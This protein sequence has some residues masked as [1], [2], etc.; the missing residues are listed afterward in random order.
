MN[1]NLYRKITIVS[2]FGFVS[3]LNVSCKTISIESKQHFETSKNITLGSIGSDENFIIEKTYTS[4][5]IPKYF[6]PIKINITPISFNSGT[7]SAF[8][9]S[10]LSQ[11]E[12][13]KINYHDS[14][15][16]KPHFLSINISDR[17]T[18]IHLLNHKENIGVKDFLLH[19]NNSHIV[20]SLSIVFNKEKTEALKQAE[21]VFLEQSGINNIALKLYNESKLVSTINFREGVVFSYRTASVCWKENSKYQLEIVDLVEGDN[22]CPNQTYKSSKRAKKDINY[23]KF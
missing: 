6:K 21:E 10:S 22:G 4:I 18:L 12:Q 9:K 2:F 14:I 3:F 1:S 23:Y 7:Y 15:Q 11:S 20:T 5:G 17:I 8:S 13:I 19:D 16:H